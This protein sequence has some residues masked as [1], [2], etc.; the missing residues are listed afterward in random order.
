MGLGIV[1]VRLR[2]FQAIQYRNN[3]SSKHIN[4]IT[5]FFSKIQILK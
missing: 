4:T 1:V 3:A 5:I 2:R